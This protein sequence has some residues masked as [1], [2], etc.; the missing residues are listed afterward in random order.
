MTKKE[1]KNYIFKTEPGRAILM[2][3]DKAVSATC[4]YPFVRYTAE[5]SRRLSRREVENYLY[6]R[7]E[8]HQ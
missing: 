1:P 4:E 6:A 8:A 2:R 7:T 3:T 5:G